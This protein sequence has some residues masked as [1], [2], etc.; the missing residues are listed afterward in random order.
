MDTQNIAI[1]FDPCNIGKRTGP[2]HLV[3]QPTEANDGLEDG[4]CS[5]RS[6]QRYKNLA[7]GNWG[8]VV[9]ET[10]Q[11]RMYYL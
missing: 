8:I 9:N 10:G 5:D 7:R 1:I 3:S 2:N 6:Y 4:K 11:Y